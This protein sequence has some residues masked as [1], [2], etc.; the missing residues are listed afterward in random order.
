MYNADV[1]LG[2]LGSTLA[3]PRARAGAAH[4]DG[5]PAAEPLPHRRRR[6]R[7]S[8]SSSS[9][10]S[11]ARRR[12]A[13]SQRVQRRRRLRRRLRRRATAFA[14]GADPRHAGRARRAARRSAA[15]FRVVSSQSTLPVKARQLG[16]TR[17]RSTYLV[18]GARHRV[19]HAHELRLRTA[20][21]ATPR[22]PPSGARSATHPGPRVVDHSSSRAGRTRASAPV[23]KFKLPG[24][25]LEDRLVPCESPCCDPQTGK[26]LTLTVIG[27]LSDTR[28]GAHGRHLVFAG[29]PHARLR[30]P[31]PADHPPASPSTPGVDP[32][33]TSGALESASSPTG[34]RPTR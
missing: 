9:R 27:V 17:R 5:L 23:P 3:R 20:R 8:R 12:R 19:P 11:S 14:G 31:R 13:R 6:W 10:S 24:F 16:T 1:L 7:C 2:A 32:K 33:L 29:H 26:Q 25:Y 34:C 30:R 18:H 15:D 21:A 22:P 4:V 28:A